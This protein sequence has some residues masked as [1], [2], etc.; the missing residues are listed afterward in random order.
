MSLAWSEWIEGPVRPPESAPRRWSNTPEAKANLTYLLT[1]PDGVELVLRRPP[2]GPVAPGPMTWPVSSR[3]CPVSGGPFPRRPAPSPSPTLVRRRS[4]RRSSSW[5][6]AV[7]IVVRGEIPERFGG[8]ADPAS[9]RAL[10][11]VVV[12]TLAEFH[13]VDPAELRSR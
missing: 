8:G 3:C 13:A 2:L 7:G 11:E 9:N 12:D 1:F 5:R 4:A 10:S 6:S